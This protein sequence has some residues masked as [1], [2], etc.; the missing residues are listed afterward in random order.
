M[1]SARGKL[2]RGELSDARHSLE[3]AVREFPRSVQLRTLLTHA[4]LR[5]NEDLDA[6]ESAL[7][8]LLKID[9]NHTEAQKNLQL[10]RQHRSH[11]LI[12]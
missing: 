8:T 9:P 1:W 10:L 2:K 7:L 11:I 3:Q 4:L 6:A 5:Q 12:N